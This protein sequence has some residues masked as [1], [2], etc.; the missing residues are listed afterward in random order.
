MFFRKQLVHGYV[1]DQGAAMFGGVAGHAGIFS[2]AND[3]AKIMYVYLKNGEYAGVKY[4]SKEVINDFSSCQFYENDNRRGAGFDKPVLEKGD[5]GPTCDGV[6]NDSFGHSG[7][8]G[9]LAWADP[10]KNIVYIFLSNRIYPDSNNKKL[11][12]MNIRTE[13]MDIIFSNFDEI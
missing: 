8:T 11:I 12:K 6:S 4:F 2:N 13:I 5:P 10:E 7:F 9:T 3:L 1:H